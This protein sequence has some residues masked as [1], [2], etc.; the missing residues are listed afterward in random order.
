MVIDVKTSSA[1]GKIDIGEDVIARRLPYLLQGQKNFVL[2]DTNVYALHR[3]FFEKWMQGEELFVLPA[4][5]EHKNFQSL[6]AILERMAAAG[7]KRTS[8]LFAVGGGVVGDIGGL[9]AALYMRGIDCVQIPTTL[10]AMV[11]SSVG[12]KTAID[13]AGV[14]NIVGAFHQPIEVLI[15]PM[16]LGT[17]PE[18]EWKCGIG[19]VVKYAA[20]DRHTFDALAAVDGNITKDLAVGLIENSV[21]YKAGV[22]ERD[23]KE[24]GERKCLN[25]GHTTGHAIELTYGLSH[26]ESVLW[27]MKIETLLAIEAGVCNPAHGARLLQFVDKA[28]ALDGGEKPDFSNLGAAAGKASLDKKNTGDGNVV[29]SVAKDYGEWTLFTLPLPQYVQAL[30]EL[31]KKL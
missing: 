15:D 17:L 25:V 14:K 3:P 2:T 23:E 5:E 16:F 31:A 11:D 18:R 13:V 19:E 1:T 8:R 20:M 28:L 26:G 24:T 27:G 22:V 9:C 21:R 10:L 30:T 29:M 4:G 6:Q 12:G 7:L